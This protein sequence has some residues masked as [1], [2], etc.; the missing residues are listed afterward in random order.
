M[1]YD[2]KYYCFMDP[3]FVDPKKGK[4]LVPFKEKWYSLRDAISFLNEQK[5]VGSLKRHHVLDE[6]AN[7]RILN[8]EG[9]FSFFSRL[10]P[11]IPFRAHAY[12]SVYI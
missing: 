5:P 11:I 1:S 2:G 9:T 8:E 3:D 7:L 4:M 6:S 12:A 10:L